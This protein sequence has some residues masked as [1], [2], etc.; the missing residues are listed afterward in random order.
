MRYRYRC[1]LCGHVV[2]LKYNVRFVRYFCEVK[3][4][5]TRLYRTNK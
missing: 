4:A 5:Y 2:F 3:Q 1:M